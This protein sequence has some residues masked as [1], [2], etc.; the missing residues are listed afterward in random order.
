MER[1]RDADKLLWRSVMKKDKRNMEDVK[2]N[3]PFLHSRRTKPN[4]ACY[5]EKCWAEFSINEGIR[6]GS[7]HFGD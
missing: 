3:F 4:D 1:L 2:N 5:K 7:R 6:V